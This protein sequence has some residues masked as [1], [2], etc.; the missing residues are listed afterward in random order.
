MGAQLTQARVGEMEQKTYSGYDMGRNITAR[1]GGR[2]M[3]MP[4]YQ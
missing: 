2:R 3:Q 1:F 4:R